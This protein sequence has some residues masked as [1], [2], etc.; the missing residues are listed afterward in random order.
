MTMNK[1]QERVVTVLGRLTIMAGKD[2]YFAEAISVDLEPL[3]DDIL[4]QDG[5]GTEGQCDPR[6]D[7][8]DFGWSMYKVEG[9]D[10]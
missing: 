7:Q 6:G 3:L 5:F 9:V 1:Q 10:D 8:R 2:E 4:S